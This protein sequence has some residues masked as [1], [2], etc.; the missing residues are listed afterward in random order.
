MIENK[1]KIM[2]NFITSSAKE[3]MSK[4]IAGTVNSKLLFLKKYFD[5][6]INDIKDKLIATLNP[7]STKF[8]EL[9]EKTPDLYGP[10]WIY[11]TLIF[12]IAAAGNLSG[13]INHP[14][15]LTKFKYDFNFVPLSAFYVNILF[16]QIY[17]I[18]FGLP[19]L[20]A[21]VMKMFSTEIS[22]VLVTMINFR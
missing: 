16:I 10:F 12:M 6:D 11:S 14:H 3:E 4:N 17:G 5:V 19:I 21:F 22:V 2:G 20:L 13:Y 9:A 8:Q 1:E 18:G 7:M 15:E